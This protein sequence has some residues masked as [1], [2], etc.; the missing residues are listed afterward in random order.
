MR[1]CFTVVF[2]PLVRYTC[3]SVPKKAS[4]SAAKMN[5]AILDPIRKRFRE[6]KQRS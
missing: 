3:N 2:R 6:I 5:I 1:V 4:L